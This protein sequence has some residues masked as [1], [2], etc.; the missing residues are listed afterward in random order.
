MKAIRIKQPGGPEAMEYG[1]AP[2]P[3]PRDGELLV[4]VHATAVNRAD[5]LQ[6]RG[7]YPPPPGASEILGLEMAGE[8]VQPAGRFKQGDRVMAVVAGGGYAELA[9]VPASQ[10]LPIP[11]NLDYTQAAAIPE[12]FETAYLNL[13][14]LGTLKAGEVTLIH[15]GASGVGTAAIQLARAA[16]ARPF[17]T[18]GTAEKLALCRRLGA[19][20]A[21]NY[22]EEKFAER[23]LQATGN[24]GADVILDFIGAP[25]WNDNLAAAALRARLMLIGFLGSP[26]GE[27]D[28]AP[29]LQKSL[30]V[31]AT[32]LRRLPAPEK[33]ALV[34]ALSEFALKRF[35][36]GELV[37]VVD[38]VY[39][40]ARA[41]DAHRHME[42][43]ANL[44]K[45]VLTVG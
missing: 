5:V 22:K 18:A 19:E 16:G 21:I 4:R 28:L 39:P 8:V 29:L 1:E 25:Y 41:A 44:G 30:T 35:A 12:A 13:F 40:L 34:A 7:L 23:V 9:A 26:R 10:A 36:R 2:D 20:L 14:T 32:T 15:A 38:S 45:I 31:R 3:T 27:L 6:R 33:E 43:N 17:A 42:A 11:D 37:P 24:R